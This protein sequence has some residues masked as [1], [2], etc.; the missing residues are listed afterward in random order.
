VQRGCTLYGSE[1]LGVGNEL[2]T[3]SGL[4]RGARVGGAGAEVKWGAVVM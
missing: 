4:R 1:N 3:L 2:C